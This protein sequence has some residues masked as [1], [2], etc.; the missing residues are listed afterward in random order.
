[1]KTKL[2]RSDFPVVIGVS[3]PAIR[4]GSVRW[5]QARCIILR[6]ESAEEM[7]GEM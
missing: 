6:E 3:G 7:R 4:G 2:T 1:M 5:N